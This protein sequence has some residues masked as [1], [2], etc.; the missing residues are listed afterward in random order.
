[1]TEVNFIDGQAL[2]PSSFGETNAQ[3]GVWQPK[4]Y[5]GSYGTNG[6]YLNFSDN[7]NTTAATLGKDYSGNG[8]NWTPN[9]FSVSAGAGNDSLVDVPT[10]WGVDTGTGGEVRGN[11]CTLNPLANNGGTLANGNLDHTGTTAITSSTLFPSTG[12]WYCEF[13]CTAYGGGASL[14]YTAVGVIQSSQSINTVPNSLASV[15]VGLWIYRN[16]A[17]K[18]NNGA[19]AS[20]GNTWT[21]NDVI[22]IAVDLDAA[23]LTFYKNGV[24]QG[25]A[26]TNLSGS[27]APAINDQGSYSSSFSFNAGQRPFAYTAPSGFKALCTQNLPTPTIGATS[28]TQADDYFNVVLWTGTGGGRTITGVG[29]QPDFV[30]GKGRSGSATYPNLVWD[31]VRGTNLNLTTNNTGAEE[32]AVTGTG[33]GGIGTSASDGFTIVA[34][35]STADNLNALSPASTYVAWAWKANGAGSSNTA[36]SITSTV[37]ANTT[38]GFS[39]VTWTGNGSSATIGHGLGV[40]PSMIIT[41]FRGDISNWSVY[42]ISTGALGRLKLNSTDAFATNAGSWN[43][44]APTSTVFSKGS[45]EN[46]NGITQVAYCFA[47]I[48]GYSRFGSYTGNGS[49]DGPFVYCGFRPALIIAK[50][51]SASG[52]NWY[53]IDDQRGPYNVVDKLLNPNSSA[54]EETYSQ[55]DFLSNG[56]KIRNTGSGMNANGATMIYAAFAEF[57]QKFS[58]AR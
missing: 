45:G 9:N 55:V 57:P 53:I 31:A 19:S 37:S 25:T 42:H 17:Q 14:G 6:F 3:T 29:F 54:A 28:T 15:P 40:A 2:T 58:L 26:Y 12:K 46:D 44:T 21:A 52:E 24:S 22:G 51:S 27:I 35:T 18:A 1:M 47:P 5:T 8:N 56:F 16:D 38:S 49:S 32:N 10:N 34:G 41:K 39:I 11:Y 48:A 33:N 36:G 30:W 23:T 4:A 43:D 20:Y 50:Q 7:S 13:T